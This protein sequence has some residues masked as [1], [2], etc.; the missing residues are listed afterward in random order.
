MY[1]KVKSNLRSLVVFIAVNLLFIATTHAQQNRGLI[2]DII[3]EKSA[4]GNE[5]PIVN[6]AKVAA[7]LRYD[8]NDFKGVIR[9]VGDLKN[10][11]NSVTSVMPGLL[12]TE[13]S[14]EYEII[15]GTLGKNKL[16]DQLVKAKKIDVSELKGKWESFVITTIENPQPGTKKSL[17]IVGSDKRGTIFGVYELSQQLGVS[18]WYWWADVPAKQRQSAYVL[19]GRYA[20]GEPK[21][22]FRGLFIN[23]EAPCLTSWVKNTYGTDHGDHRFYARVF[24]LILRLKGNYLWPAMWGWAFYAD[25]PMNSKVADEMGVIIGTSHHEPMARNHQEWTRNR[26]EHGSWNYATNQKVIDKFF[27]DGIE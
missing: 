11:I 16:I 10:D 26:K 15:V 7:S 25:D 19:P 5:F 20:S 1:Q 21:V 9:A 6:A 4:S 3:L 8:V 27:T 24:E 13:A 18:P 12:T 22:K 23:D 17:V 2:S 14:T